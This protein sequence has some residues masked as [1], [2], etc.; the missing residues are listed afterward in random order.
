MEGKREYTTLSVPIE[1]IDFLKKYIVMTT[2]TIRKGDLIKLFL[3]AI[4]SYL[5]GKIPENLKEEYNELKKK[6]LE[7]SED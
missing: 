1:L 7:E 6:Y 3:N 5:N 2:G 4:F